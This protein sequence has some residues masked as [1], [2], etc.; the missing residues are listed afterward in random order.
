[1]QIPF[2]ECLC[3]KCGV[4]VHFFEGDL[5]EGI[6]PEEIPE[7]FGCIYCGGN[8]QV[9]KVRGEHVFLPTRYACGVRC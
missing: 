2:A 1:M 4:E 8:I 7:I 5:P 9:R 6:P 3:L